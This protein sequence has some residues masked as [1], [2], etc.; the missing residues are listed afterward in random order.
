MKTKKSPRKE[1]YQTAARLFYRS[2][3]RATGVDVI[4]AESGVGKMT[5]YRYYPSKDDLIFDY[6]IES[7]RDFWEKFEAI[8]GRA[9]DAR[10]KLLAFFTSLEAYV[11]SPDCY[12][13]PFINLSSE[14]PQ[15]DYRGHQIALQN[16]QA[17]RARFTDLAREAGADHPQTLANGL[18]LLM[19]GA[20]IAARMWG[21]AE[22][23]PARGLAESARVLVDA[24]LPA[25]V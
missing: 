3:Y 10:E 17:V 20:Y 23:S 25:H 4:S 14:Y 1:L 13:C 7:D 2:G 16:K 24:S 19:D 21:A 9:G 11:T 22:D 18:L 15:Q 5:L 12:G 6:L 8:T